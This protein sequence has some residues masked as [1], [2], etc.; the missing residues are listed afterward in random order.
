MVEYRLSR[1][2][3]QALVEIYIHTAQTFG[4]LQAAAYHEGF[5]RT[6]GLI[7][8]FPLMGNSA[9]ELV[10]GWRQ[11]AHGKHVIFYSTD[12]DEAIVVQA[13]FHSAQNVRKHL[14]DD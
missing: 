9:D 13:I 8:D 11:F 12:A 4:D 1:K 2:A 7:A 14:F 3:D 10:S 6:F 5:H